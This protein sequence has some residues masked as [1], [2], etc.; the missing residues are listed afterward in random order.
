MIH[1][2]CVYALQC[3]DLQRGRMRI[4]E[5]EGC[6]VCLLSKIRVNIKS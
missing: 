1:V 5:V 4:E 3:G 2:R 6:R